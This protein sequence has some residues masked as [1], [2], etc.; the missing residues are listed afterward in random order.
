MPAVSSVCCGNARGPIALCLPITVCH[1]VQI[2][3][4]YSQ[5][6]GLLFIMVVGHRCTSCRSKAVS[7]G[8]YKWRRALL[9]WKTTLIE[10]ETSRSSMWGR[11]LQTRNSFQG[12]NKSICGSKGPSMNGRG[13]MREA[14]TLSSKSWPRSFQWNGKKVLDD[15]FLAA[16]PVRS[17]ELER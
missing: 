12:R 3:E 6:A 17:Y 4:W 14:V 13:I 2:E 16:T 15:S 8:P 11:T 7:A 1:T 5:V 9:H 10:E